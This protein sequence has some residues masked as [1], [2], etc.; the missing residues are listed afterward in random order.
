MSISFDENISEISQDVINRTI[1][2]LPHITKAVEIGRTFSLLKARYKA[3]LA[4]LDHVQVGMAVALSSGEIVVSNSEAKRI[5]RTGDGL[6]LTKANKITSNDST[7]TAKIEHAIKE[8]CGTAIGEGDTPECLYTVPRLSGDHE[9]LI[10]I[11]PLKDSLKE[12]DP[13]LHGSLITI[14]DPL[15]VP[16][17]P[18]DRFARLYGLTSAESD[19]LR[20]L[21]NGSSLEEISEQRS[22]SPIT[23]RN[24]TTSILEKTGTRR[25]AD[26]IRLVIRV[27]PPVD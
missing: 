11:A 20:H 14:I 22:T 5:F 16:V 3:A 18:T 23:V 1:N 4:T 6:A 26:L 8:A 21:I 2:L 27:M 15:T 25:R 7:M 9:F 24:Q 12:L 10:D 17:P 13:S 19:I